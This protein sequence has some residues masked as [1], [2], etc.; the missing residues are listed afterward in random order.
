MPIDLRIHSRAV[1]PSNGSTSRAVFCSLSTARPMRSRAGSES[2]PKRSRCIGDV[3]GHERPSRKNAIE[4]GRHSSSA[5]IPSSVVEL[6]DVAVARE[7]V[8][9]VALEQVAAADVDRRGLAAEP[10]PALVDVGPVALLAEAVR[11]HEA[12]DAGSDDGDPHGSSRRST[13]ASAA[14]APS[15]RSRLRALET[16]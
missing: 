3:N 8:V 10:R 4:D 2:G 11:A 12:G 14:A 1:M 5:G 16:T 15:S 6:G 13:P 9:V 7:Q